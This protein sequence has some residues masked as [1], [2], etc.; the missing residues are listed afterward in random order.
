M[1]PKFISRCV[2]LQNLDVKPCD[3]KMVILDYKTK[4]EK[5]ASFI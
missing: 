1:S 4:F 3:T 5:T 2:I